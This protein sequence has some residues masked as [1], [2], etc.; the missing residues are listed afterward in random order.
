MTETVDLDIT[1]SDEETLQSLI[2]D[3]PTLIKQINRYFTGGPEVVLL[4]TLVW[5]YDDEPDFTEEGRL[6][7][8][9]LTVNCIQ[10]IL[11]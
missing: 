3:N 11:I 2:D 7:I 1:K 10:L 9:Q 4:P 5:N 8:Y 6:L